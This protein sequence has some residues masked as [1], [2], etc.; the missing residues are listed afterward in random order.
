MSKGIK[1]FEKDMAKIGKACQDPKNLRQA[2]QFIQGAAKLNAPGGITGFL[3]NS[4]DYTLT[5]D[6]GG[7]EAVIGTNAEYAMYV[8]FGTGPKGAANHADSSPDFKPTYT[9]EPWWV[10][11]SQLDP[12]AIQRYHW[13]SI[14]TEKGRFYK[15]SGQAAHP[16]LYP[17]LKD[18]ESTVAKL[19]AEGL[20]G[21]IGK[22]VK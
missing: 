17:A 19:V 5:G 3:R 7:L 16:F 8:E 15:I 20:E 21:A 1:D 18:N 10:H 4:I 14:V 22:V 6:E 12:Q 13:P 2:A 9:L 11:E